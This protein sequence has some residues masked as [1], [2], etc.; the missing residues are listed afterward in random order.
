[1]KAGLDLEMPE[2]ILKNFRQLADF[3]VHRRIVAAALP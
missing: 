2:G 1:M 3:P